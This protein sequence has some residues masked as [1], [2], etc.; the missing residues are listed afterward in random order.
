M[1]SQPSVIV[2]CSGGPASATLAFLLGK[3]DWGLPKSHMGPLPS[4]LRLERGL[5]AEGYA[6][7]LLTIQQERLLLQEQR[8]ARLV[9]GL[10][11]VPYEV[12]D[13]AA[14]MRVPT[15][16]A[17]PYA[18]LF[19]LAGA[20]AV[21]QEALLIA[22]GM[23]AP[24][25]EACAAFVAGFNLVAQS[26][27][28]VPTLPSLQ[29]LTPL[30]GEHL[31]DLFALGQHLGVPLASTWSCEQGYALQC[32]RCQAC[33]RRQAAFRLAGVPDQTHYHAFTRAAGKEHD[34]DVQH[35]KGRHL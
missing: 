12:L 22:A 17:A 34:S 6:L 13:P 25:S 3:K 2:L 33:Q 27:S 31:P 1:G 21:R 15:T 20:I 16:E 4:S 24:A 8:A 26:G 11:D 19:A 29:L 14:L 5:S 18:R 10:L 7:H 30:A 9:A 32:G 28:I 23:Y 35:Q